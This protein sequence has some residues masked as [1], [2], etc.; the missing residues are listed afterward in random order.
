MAGL[1]H[2]TGVG[3]AVVA[4]ALVVTG[5]PASAHIDDPP[6][7]SAPGVVTIVIDPGHDRYANL[8]REPIGPGSSAFKIKDG[9]GTSGVATGQREA[10]FNLRVGLRL[11]TLLRNTPGIRVVMTRTRTCCVSKGN[12]ARAKIANRAHASLFLRIHADGSTNN[13]V[14]GTSTLYPAVHRGWTDDIAGRSRRAAQLVHRRLVRA[15]G[16]PNR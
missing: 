9:G 12:I 7:G 11:R 10:T 2:G 13:S 1:R 15:L 14:R 16:F 4:A 6:P 3:A 8:D 5:S